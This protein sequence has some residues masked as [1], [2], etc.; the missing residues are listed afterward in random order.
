MVMYRKCRKV[1]TCGFWT[2]VFWAT[3]CKTVRPMLSDRCLSYLS[4]PVLSVMFVNC[5]QMVG[6]IKMKLSLQV[7]IGPGHIV[8]DGDP[9]LLPK[10]AQL[11]AHIC[12]RPNGCMDQDV[13]WYGARPWPR[14][15]CVK[16]GPRSLLCKMGAEPRPDPNF[17]PVFIV[18]KRLDG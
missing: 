4:C 12:L 6:R 5:G 13:T 11:S 9:A 1:W 2:T 10:G 3:V 17:R 8:L 18:A 14:R 16:W 7:G 15:L